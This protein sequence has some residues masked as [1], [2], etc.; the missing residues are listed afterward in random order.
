[1][2]DW[3]DFFFF[4]SAGFYNYAICFLFLKF[5]IHIIPEMIKTHSR[6][7]F[8]LSVSK[9]SISVLLTPARLSPLCSFGL[10]PFQFGSMN[11]AS[12]VQVAGLVDFFCL[13]FPLLQ[14]VF[15]CDP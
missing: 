4:P 6:I 12:S 14:T 9:V 13:V 1:M 3:V 2:F 11:S 5:R 8:F 10:H 15:P 7:Y